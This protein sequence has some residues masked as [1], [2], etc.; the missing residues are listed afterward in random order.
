MLYYAPLITYSIFKISDNSIFDI[1]ELKVVSQEK[2]FKVLES[3]LS[4]FFIQSTRFMSSNTVPSHNKNNTPK[5]IKYFKYLIILLFLI[6]SVDFNSIVIL[7]SKLT[8]TK[9]LLLNIILAL[10]YLI[11]LIIDLYIFTLFLF[12][13]KN[14]FFIINISKYIFKYYSN[15]VKYLFRY[16]PLYFYG[17]CLRKKNK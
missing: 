6:V 13:I 11:Y 16:M 2:D 7:L 15:K 12:K 8:F 3:I 10:M 1:I 9:V 14:I 17:I 5:F 4:F